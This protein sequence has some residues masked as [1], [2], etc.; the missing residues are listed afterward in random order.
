MHVCSNGVVCSSNNLS[1]GN[2]TTLVVWQNQVNCWEVYEQA[3]ARLCN[4]ASTVN[5]DTQTAAELLPAAGD[6]Y[7]MLKLLKIVA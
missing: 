2:L 5:V 6:A 1:H 3:W 7:A 4:I